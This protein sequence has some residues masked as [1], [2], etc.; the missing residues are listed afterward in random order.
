MDLSILC[1]GELQPIAPMF[2]ML[3]SFAADDRIC[4]KTHHV[5]SGL[6]ILLPNVSEQRL[7][8]AVSPILDP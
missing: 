3:Q 8:H 2:Y 6:G 5:P 7:K 1:P 4:P